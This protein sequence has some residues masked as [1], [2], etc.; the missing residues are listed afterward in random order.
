MKTQLEAQGQKVIVVE[1]PAHGDDNTAPENVS[2]NVYRDK[3]VSA[4]NAVDGKVV[5]VGHSMAGVVVSEVADAIPDKL[6]KLIYVAAF[7]PAN[8]QSLQDLAFQDAQSQLGPSLIPSQD[9]LTLDVKQENRI[10][11]FCQDGSDE[12]KALLTQKFRVEPAIPF[13]NK[14]SLSADKFGKV[15]KY[16]IHT[17]QDHA[18][19]PD[20]QDKMANA[21]GITKTYTL[22][23][24]HS[25]FLSVP[26][27]LTQ[28]LL[29]I[30]K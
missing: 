17:S 11:I 13:T 27:Q 22:N 26:D 23:S 5:L 6:E 25:P 30:T 21:A 8:G 2:I 29:T 28:Q 18:I 16:Y 3:V 14:A 20:L 12:A 24:G 10:N 4:I 7:V 19:G 9:M 15:D 1:L